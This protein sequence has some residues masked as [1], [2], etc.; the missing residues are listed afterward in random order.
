MRFHI[1]G[2]GIPTKCDAQ[3][4]NCPLT[5]EDGSPMPHFKNQDEAY[6]Y[7]EEKSEAEETGGVFRTL[8]KNSEETYIKNPEKALEKLARSMRNYR[9][10]PSYLN[11]QKLSK[12]R[13]EFYLT[14]AGIRHL[15]EH[16]LPGEADHYRFESERLLEE[17][18]KMEEEDF[19]NMKNGKEAR[20][21][22]PSLKVLDTGKLM[23]MTERIADDSSIDWGEE[24]SPEKFKK[25]LRKSAEWH[26]DQKRRNRGEYVMTPYIDHPMRNAMRAHRWGVKD[27]EVLTSILLHDTVEDCSHKIN[28]D[29]KPAKRTHQKKEQQERALKHLEKDYGERVSKMVGN[30]TNDVLRPDLPR[31]EKDKNYVEHLEKILPDSG[32]YIGKFS[33][34]TDN[35]GGLHHNYVA[36]SEKSLVKQYNKYMMALPVFEKHYQKVKKD[37]NPK[38]QENIGK[39]LSHV[40]RNLKELGFDLKKDGWID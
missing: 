4:G 9:K 1:S 24:G 37:Y 15:E 8:K 33:D 14:P 32:T 21:S 11:L 13:R 16:G 27:G 29:N 19:K 28:G 26:K 30:M 10:N 35:A 17:S 36:G 18:K 23:E 25:A 5:E 20:P 2:K 39:Q 22:F 31:E 3:P 12:A 6:K 40:R 34:F 7:I 38:V